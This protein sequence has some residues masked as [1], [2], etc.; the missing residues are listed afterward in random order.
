MLLGGLKD[1]TGSPTGG[2]LVFAAAAGA[3]AAVLVCVAR[4]WEGAFV[5]RGGLAPQEAG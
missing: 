2:F 1:L 4:A 5:A 3:S